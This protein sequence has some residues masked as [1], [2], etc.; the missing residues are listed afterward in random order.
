MV[1]V[2]AIGTLDAAMGTLGDAGM[3]L[4]A[5]AL[6]ARGPLVPPMG[7]IMPGVGVITLGGIIE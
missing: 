1:P 3:A 4:C 6:V 2:P 7:A 5:G